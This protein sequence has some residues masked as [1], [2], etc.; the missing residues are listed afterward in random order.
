MRNI[1]IIAGREIK[2]LRARFGGKMIATV[3]V[4]LAAA[5]GVSFLVYLQGMVLARDFYNIGVSPGAPGLDD[6]RFHIINVDTGRAG[7]ALQSG[8]IDAYLSGRT[9]FYRQDDRSQYAAGAVRTYL[10]T[11]ELQ[12]V[13]TQYHLNQA[14]PLRVEVNYLKAPSKAL[15]SASVATLADIMGGVSNPS[16]PD[17]KSGVIQSD[18]MGEELNMSSSPGQEISV[19]SDASVMRQLEG[20]GSSRSLPEFKAEFATDR[21]V[22]VPSLMTPPIPLA[23]VLLA[24]L[25]I[26][27]IFFISIFFT[28]GFIEEKMGR[29][30]NILLST[31]VTP[32]QVIVGKMLPYIGYSLLIVLAITVVL[33]GNP[34]LAVAIFLPVI[35]FIFA[36]YLGVALQYRTFKDQTFFSL[37]AVTGITGYLV[38]PAMFV[39]INDLSYVSPLTLAV[40][41]YRG[42][43]ITVMQY[44]LSAIPMLLVFVLAL[45]VGTRV[46][47]EEYL[48]SFRPIHVKVREA[49]Y[50]AIDK[51][52]IAISVALF[53]LLLIPVVF[54]VEMGVITLAFNL[55]KALALGLVIFICVVIEEMTKSLTVAVA[56]ERGLAKKW[57]QV[58]LLAVVSAA[59][60][61]L[62]EKLLLFMSLKVISE[63]IFTAAVFASNALWI[64]LVVHSICTMMVCLLTFR[65]GMKGYPVALLAGSLMH[66]L[67][68]MFL[69]GVFK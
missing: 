20:L 28:S 12:R 9:I 14:F 60:F 32:L 6:Q 30:I 48:L 49:I 35:L 29:K 25:Y 41:M 10:K 38:F 57:Q 11:G 16:M 56:I 59:F 8:E 51:R 54:M 66:G 39:G 65:L 64:P 67:Y 21:E 13:A 52:H 61:F 50:F 34:L 55:P 43:D 62:G 3:A 27:P 63:S 40:Q 19:E 24:F 23:Q 31:P 46:F 2:R 53:S 7:L 58:V 15:G 26:L 18:L 47:N 36:I 44:M 33:R 37:L 22:I 5:A 1:L 17:G 4:L 69:V 45:V 42:A 68:N